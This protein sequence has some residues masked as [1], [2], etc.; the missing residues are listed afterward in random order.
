[1]VDSSGNITA[2][3][4]ISGGAAAPGG[5]SVYSD[6]LDAYYAFPGWLMVG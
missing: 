1:M 4:I 6:I 5:I 2:K 3:G